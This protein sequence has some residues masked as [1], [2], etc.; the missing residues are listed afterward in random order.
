MVGGWIAVMLDEHCFEPQGGL[1]LPPVVNEGERR[2]A[3]GPEPKLSVLLVDVC[4]NF[5]L[6]AGDEEDCF[7]RLIKGWVH[8]SGCVGRGGIVCDVMD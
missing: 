4:V 3:L 6:I 7:E 5:E 1:V 2:N 8:C